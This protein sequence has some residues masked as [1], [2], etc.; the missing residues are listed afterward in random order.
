M[1]SLRL[2]SL[3]LQNFRC[4]ESCDIEFHP[5]LTVLVAENGKGKTALLDAASL[6]LSAFVNALTPAERLR[7]LERSD[8]RLVPTPADGMQP[9]LPSSLAAS[10]T[11]AG[12]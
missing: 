1:T 10:G 12:K 5:E 8:V 4:F 9:Q 2:K 11:V 6:A 3:T 7:K